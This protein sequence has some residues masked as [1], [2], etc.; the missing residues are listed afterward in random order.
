MPFYL[1]TFATIVYKLFLYS[2]ELYVV[3]MYLYITMPVIVSF[4]FAKSL[5]K[6]SR[7]NDI[8]A[9]KYHAFKIIIPAH[10][11]SAVI[12]ALLESIKNLDY[13]YAETLV[14]ADNCIDNTA[15]IARSFEV[16]CIE[17]KTD[18]P[19]SKG[20][21][22]QF[23]SE[24][25][26]LES[27][28]QG[29]VVLVDADCQLETDFLSEL[30]KKLQE[31]NAAPVIQ[32]YRYVSNK[33]SN[34]IATM[35]SASEAIRQWITLGSRKILGLNSFI[36]G[37]GVAFEKELF[38][39]LTNNNRGVLVEDKQWNAEL[40]EQNI[41]IDWCPSAKLNYEV[42]NT[43]KDFQKQRKRW[44]SGQFDLAKKYF[45]RLFF[46][47]IKAG[48][49]SKIDFSLSLIQLPRSAFMVAIFL[50]ALLSYYT[51][52]NLVSPWVYLVLL[53]SLICY[54]FIGLLLIEADLKFY[55][56]LF[57]GS[58]VFVGLTKSTIYS[59]LG[60]RDKKW[61]ATVRTPPI[62]KKKLN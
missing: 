21:A 44:I 9:S 34:I 25:L 50:L 52:S 55:F 4:I 11:E 1:Y 10:N 2:I 30:N 53:L 3:L 59:I 57:L 42:V 24:K 7:S 56:K 6:M 49:F 61:I 8:P 28:P 33:N 60:I 20:E 17:R 16:N 14:I 32:A 51:G 13:P 26:T 45:L 31:P 38:I 39:R 48:N 18:T 54:G 58:M 37:S 12:G 46:K 15:E 41:G 40:L 47:G 43:N 22:L 19:S 29:Y 5:K 27:T 35:D 36:L 23:A 62:I